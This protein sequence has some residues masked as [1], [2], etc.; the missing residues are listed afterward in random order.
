MTRRRGN[1]HIGGPAILETTE[2]GIR[3]YAK[4]PSIPHI[5]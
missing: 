3:R 4:G 1:S 2:E 5:L